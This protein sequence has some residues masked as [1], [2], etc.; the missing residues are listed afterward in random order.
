MYFIK[1]YQVKTSKTLDAPD[2]NIFLEKCWI[3]IT[4]SCL[5]KKKILR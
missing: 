3:I 4:P 1:I 5:Y 2:E